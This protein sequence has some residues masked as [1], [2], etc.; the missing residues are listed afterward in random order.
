MK[1]GILTRH[2]SKTSLE[3]TE[4]M[5]NRA[6]S[7]PERV[8]KNEFLTLVSAVR[9]IKKETAKQHLNYLLKN[10]NEYATETI[11]NKIYILRKVD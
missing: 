4:E 8:E 10:S 5:L 6:L 7:S 2:V 11:N 1:L 9:N 3:L